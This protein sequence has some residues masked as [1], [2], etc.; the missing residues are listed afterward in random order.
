MLYDN[1]IQFR[2]R[3]VGMADEVD[4]KS[5]GGN[6]VRVQVPQPADLKA[7]ENIGF[8]L[9]FQGLSVFLQVVQGTPFSGSGTP[10]SGE[11][12]HEI[13]HEKRLIFLLFS[14]RTSS[15]IVPYITQFIGYVRPEQ[16]DPR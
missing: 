10:F 9:Y 11:I 5:I 12:S 13:S 6:T 14:R 2:R 8:F 16:F 4:S 3:L 1:F 7:L 15:F